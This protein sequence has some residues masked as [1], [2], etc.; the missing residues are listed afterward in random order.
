MPGSLDQLLPESGDS[1]DLADALRHLADTY[2]DRHGHLR[3]ESE[4]LAA[5]PAE[6]A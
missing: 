2:P 5:E 3:A 4:E 1:S 6:D